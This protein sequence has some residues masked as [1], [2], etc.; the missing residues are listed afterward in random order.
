MLKR[1]CSNS[2]FVLGLY[3]AVNYDLNDDAWSVANAVRHILYAV[4]YR[5]KDANA[6]VFFIDCFFEGREK[7]HLR[8][9]EIEH[10]FQWLLYAYN[11]E[12]K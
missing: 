6:L 9:P 4:N 7:K 12:G 2:A 3:G 1:I 11:E 10:A 5:S 8:D